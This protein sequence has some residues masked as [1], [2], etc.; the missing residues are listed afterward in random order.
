M[1]DFDCSFIFVVVVVVNYHAE[2]HLQLDLIHREKKTMYQTSLHDVVNQEYLSSLESHLIPNFQVY[3]FL[4]GI[5]VTFKPTALVNMYKAFF[6]CLSLLI[7]PHLAQTLGLGWCSSA[8]REAE[9][10][11]RVLQKRYI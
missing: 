6:L 5:L 3:N 4:L 8:P 2:K 1:N 7:P 9:T 11:M 10:S